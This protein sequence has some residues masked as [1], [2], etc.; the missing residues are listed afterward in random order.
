MQGLLGV[1]IMWLFFRTVGGTLVI[2]NLTFSTLQMLLKKPE[3]IFDRNYQDVYSDPGE[4]E[5]KRNEYGRYVLDIQNN[6]AFLIGDGYSPKGQFP[7][8]DAFNLKS[9]TTKR[10]YHHHIL[11]NWSV[12][13][14]LWMLRRENS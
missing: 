14:Q 10:I 13:F 1:M 9:K 5:T 2:Q 11:I 3:V 4:F 6:Q 7:F 8:V 12:S